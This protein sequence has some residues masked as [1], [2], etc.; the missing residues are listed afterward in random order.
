MQIFYV[1]KLQFFKNAIPNNTV[2]GIL[3]KIV[4]FT[5]EITTPKGPLF[6]LVYIYFG[7]KPP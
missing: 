4:L 5:Y 3:L 7:G 1:F 2:Y 6:L